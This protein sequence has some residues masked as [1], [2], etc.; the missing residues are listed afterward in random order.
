MTRRLRPRTL[1]RRHVTALALLLCGVLALAAS[2][3]R[4]TRHATTASPSATSLPAKIIAHAGDTRLCA[5]VSPV[6]F[7]QVTGQHANQVERG[8]TSDTLTGLQEVYCIYLDT[9]DPVQLF[10]RGTINFEIAENAHSAA[11]TFEAVR[12]AFTGVI[13]IADVGDAAFAGSPGGA[14]NG[15]GLVVVKGTLLLYLSV[16]G[17]P[18]TVAHVTTQLATL[19]LIRVAS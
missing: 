16:G 3:E 9:S 2:A 14:G 8:A 10:G 17:D 18:R 12:Q 6:E 4:S 7:E 15:T 5:A 19:V 11:H 1:P 13:D